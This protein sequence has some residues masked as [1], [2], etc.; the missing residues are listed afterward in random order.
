[1]DLSIPKVCYINLNT[2]TAGHSLANYWEPD[3]SPACS[4]LT[5]SLIN[6]I[7]E[8]PLKFGGAIPQN[9]T[10]FLQKKCEELLQCILL[11]P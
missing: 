1:M 4:K 5:N 10:I 8:F 7:L 9:A 3:Q 11:S 2:H 6:A